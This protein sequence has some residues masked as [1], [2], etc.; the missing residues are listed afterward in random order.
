MPLTSRLHRD[1]IDTDIKLFPFE[2]GQV[3]SMNNF[4]TS[5]SFIHGELMTTDITL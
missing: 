3:G 2:E 1:S 5:R 4:G